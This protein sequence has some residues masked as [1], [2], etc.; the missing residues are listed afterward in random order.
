MRLTHAEVRENLFRYIANIIHGDVVFRRA[1]TLIL[2]R[3]LPRLIA[4]INWL[5]AADGDGS[6]NLIAFSL[7]L[8]KVVNDRLIKEEVHIA[9]RCLNDTVEIVT[10][11]VRA[12][13]CPAAHQK[14][15]DHQDTCEMHVA[16]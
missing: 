8:E 13:Y 3:R 12:N 14:C 10:M 11:L 16:A 15:P 1:D 7:R 2:E 9:V 6:R 4:G 5:V